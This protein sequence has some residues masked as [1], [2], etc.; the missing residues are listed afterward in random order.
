MSLR[1]VCFCFFCLWS[2]ETFRS[3]LAKKNGLCKEKSENLTYVNLFQLIFD[4]PS[5]LK[6]QWCHVVASAGIL[7]PWVSGSST[8]QSFYLPPPLQKVIG[9]YLLPS[10]Q[11]SG[12]HLAKE[13]R[14]YWGIWKIFL[15]IVVVSKSVISA[16][17][18]VPTPSTSQSQLQG[19]S[20][21][22]P[23]PGAELMVSLPGQSLR[24]D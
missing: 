23:D 17:C 22:V 19:S 13:S 15:G 14:P 21:E 6:S 8:G 5:R 1:F 9:K 7:T 12:L 3:H 20:Q 4:I 10:R 24:W 18:L 11:R 2:P 16:L